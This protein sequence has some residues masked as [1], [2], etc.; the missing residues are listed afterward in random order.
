MRPI[1][2]GLVDGR[3]GFDLFSADKAPSISTVDCRRKRHA[4]P[5]RQRLQG[6]SRCR[7]G[8]EEVTSTHASHLPAF[9]RGVLVRSTNKKANRQKFIRR[10]IV[11]GTYQGS[12]G[13]H[14]QCG[15]RRSEAKCVITI[16]RSLWKPENDLWLQVSVVNTESMS[17]RDCI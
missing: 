11:Y 16:R 10:V 6:R 2:G 4:L 14:Y 15:S 13:S 5:R 12:C 3:L 7:I 17:V 8:L 1:E 9:G